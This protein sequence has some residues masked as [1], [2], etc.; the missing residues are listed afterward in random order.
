MIIMD[1][2]PGRNDPCPC[3]SG[4][5]YKK[6]CWHND[7]KQNPTQE[8]REDLQDLLKD[9]EFSSLDEVNSHIRHYMEKRN[10]APVDEFH[11]LSSHQMHRLL[12]FPFESPDVIRFNFKE[13]VT[14]PENAPLTR[15]L[16]LIV[17]AIG[18]K[19]LKPTA[20]GNLPRYISREI[21][22][23][24]LPPER[25]DYLTQ[26]GEFRS[27][28]EIPDL[29]EVRFVSEMAGYIRK[30]KGRFIVTRKCRKLLEANDWAQIYET[31]FKIF[32]RKYNWGY[33]SR[34]PEVPFFRESFAFTLYLLHK[35]GN[36]SRSTDFYADTVIEAFPVLFQGVPESELK[37]YKSTLNG[38]YISEVIY[39]FG[40]I[41]GVLSAEYGFGK[42]G[43]EA[44]P[45]LKR[46]V[47]F[48]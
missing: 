25:Y 39:T 3:G 21:A 1:E 14:R 48:K 36:V 22:R 41:S 45:L 11:G 16:A 32:V 23:L 38:S 17:D 9:N 37:I 34:F 28:N 18:E 40:E 5:K 31:L 27:E 46:L 2:K 33:N 29:Q 43:V 8:I 10:S 35:Y 19:G 13:A 47:T 42:Y 12:H 26:L 6:C 4:K 15:L 24:Y 30:Y 44:L 7:A 20:T